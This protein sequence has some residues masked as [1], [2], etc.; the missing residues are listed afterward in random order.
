MQGGISS[1]LEPQNTGPDVRSLYVFLS[2]YL[3][4]ADSRVDHETVRSGPRWDCIGDTESRVQLTGAL[5][6]QCRLNSGSLYTCQSRFPFG[7]C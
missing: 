5:E 3:G 2:R 7:I 4:T 1:L 6:V